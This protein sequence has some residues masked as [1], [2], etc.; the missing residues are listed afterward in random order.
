MKRIF[1]DKEIVQILAREV[2][3]ERNMPAAVDYRVSADF[4]GRDNLF[5]VCIEL[6]EEPRKEK[7][8]Q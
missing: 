5:T 6:K 4:K 2:I 7:K 1:V 8:D 3:R